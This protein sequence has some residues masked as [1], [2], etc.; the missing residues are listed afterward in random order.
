MKESCSTTESAL[1]KA[2]I[3]GIM[4]EYARFLIESKDFKSKNIGIMNLSYK[5]NFL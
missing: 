4:I 2:G 3:K 5:P 1:K